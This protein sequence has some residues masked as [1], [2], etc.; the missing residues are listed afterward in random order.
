M[1]F[2]FFRYLTEEWKVRCSDMVQ[3]SAYSPDA[4]NMRYIKADVPPQPNGTDCGVYTIKFAEFL[5]HSFPRTTQADIESGFRQ[6]IHKNS[7]PHAAVQQERVAIRESLE[8]IHRQ[9]TERQER[10]A[11]ERDERRKR[12]AQEKAAVAAAAAMAEAEASSTDRTPDAKQ[13]EDQVSLSEDSTVSVSTSSTPVV[14]LSPRLATSSSVYDVSSSQLTQ[15]QGQQQ[16]DPASSSQ[17]SHMTT[18]QVGPAETDIPRTFSGD[19]IQVTS[20]RDGD[21]SADDHDEV[22][23]LQGRAGKRTSSAFKTYGKSSNDSKRTPKKPVDTNESDTSTNSQSAA[24]T[25]SQDSQKIHAS[26]SGKK[27]KLSH[28]QSDDRQSYLTVPVVGYFKDTFTQNVES[29]NK[30][31]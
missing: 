24:Q 3:S 17:D 12:R 29:I 19:D 7:F 5:L 28:E 9:Y 22:V 30:D 4:Q 2:N 8:S 25:Q 6:F 23:M 27:Q 20:S 18:L 26:G 14:P 11:R 16:R 10:K 15:E 1:V 31:E 13:G 21:S